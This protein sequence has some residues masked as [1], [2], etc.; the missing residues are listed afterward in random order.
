MWQVG[1]GFEVLATRTMAYVR[2]AQDQQ[3]GAPRQAHTKHSGHINVHEAIVLPAFRPP[4]RGLDPQQ[5]MEDID[6]REDNDYHNYE[7]DFE[8]DQE[9]NRH[10]IDEQ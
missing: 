7:P 5:N 3:P 6:H 4:M 1:E 8:P 2:Q 9:G 10:H